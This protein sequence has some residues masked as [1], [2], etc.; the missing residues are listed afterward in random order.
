MTMRAAPN[1]AGPWHLVVDEDAPAA[2]SISSYHPALVNLQDVT[3]R[4]G[5][6]GVA[7]GEIAGIVSHA[8]VAVVLRDVSI[9]DSHRNGVRVATGSAE[10]I[11][12]IIAGHGEHGLIIPSSGDARL[13]LCTVSNNGA[14]EIVALGYKTSGGI[15]VSGSGSIELRACRIEDNV[16]TGLRIGD[17]ATASVSE[18]AIIDNVEDGIL[19]R[20]HA[21]LHLESC[22]MDGNGGFG[23]RF[24]SATC[25]NGTEPSPTNPFVGLVTGTGNTIPDNSNAGGNERGSICPESFRFLAEE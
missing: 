24:V 25:V 13:S 7:I 17:R 11:D 19:A 16:G 23:V 18:S 5:T 1:S 10:L 21:S 9:L 3:I 14:T 8:P 6:V 12:C 22:V 2:I 4:G 20:G 15:D